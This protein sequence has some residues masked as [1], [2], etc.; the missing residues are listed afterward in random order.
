LS[1][2]KNPGKIVDRDSDRSTESFGHALFG[3][4]QSRSLENTGC[5]SDLRTQCQS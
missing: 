3:M 1:Y 4:L 5:M 2:V